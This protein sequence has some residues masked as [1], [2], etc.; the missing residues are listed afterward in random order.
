MKNNKKDASKGGFSILKETLGLIEKYGPIRI[1][2]GCLMMLFV[3]YATYISLNPSVIFEKYRE[4]EEARHDESFNYRMKVIPIVQSYVDNLL[5]DIKADRSY[6][7]E[8]HNG[9]Y[10]PTGLS[11]NYGSL[12]YE[13]L[14]DS[15]QSV[16]EDYADFTLERYP[17]LVKAY[18]DGYW[19]G[20][21][22]ELR[23]IDKSIA[24]KMEANGCKYAAITIIYGSKRDIGFLGVSFVN[25]PPKN[26]DEISIA[27]KKYSS[28]ISPYLDGEMAKML[29]K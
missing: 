16:R 15:I 1:I 25:K 20:S 19:A 23:T 17:V 6:I 7:I 13:S 24:L 3:S 27:L 8:M 12:T 2:T 4:Y 22:D 29:V 14:N 18:K 21:L 28:K 11:F 10:N 9:K 26:K 5:L